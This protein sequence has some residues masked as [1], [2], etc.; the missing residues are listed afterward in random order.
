MLDDYI[1]YLI[2]HKMINLAL[3]FVPKDKEDNT[4]ANILLT[5]IYNKLSPDVLEKLINAYNGNNNSL[6][7]V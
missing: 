4:K 7:I 5:H 6:N 1:T 2:D 3:E